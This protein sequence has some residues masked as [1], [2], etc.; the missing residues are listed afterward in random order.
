M[1]FN[2]NMKNM[3]TFGYLKNVYLMQKIF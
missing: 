2:V 1:L 3:F